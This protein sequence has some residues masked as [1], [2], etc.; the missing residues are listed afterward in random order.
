MRCA[1]WSAPVLFPNPEDMF[2]CAEAHL[3]TTFFNW[4]YLILIGIQNSGSQDFEFTR[5]DCVKEESL[6][7]ILIR[8]IVL[9]VKIKINKIST[10]C[11]V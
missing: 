1:G 11:A 4:K 7:F 8:T 10:L 3:I 2:S 6:I 5:L 9:S